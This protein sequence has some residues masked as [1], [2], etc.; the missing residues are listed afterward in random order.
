MSLHSFC[1][2]APAISFS[3]RIGRSATRLQ[4]SVIHESSL[5]FI[6]MEANTGSRK[7][8]PKL[9]NDVEEHQLLLKQADFISGS[10]VRHYYRMTS[11]PILRNESY[12]SRL[13]N[14]ASTLQHEKLEEFNLS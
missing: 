9:V 7:W 6:R 14:Q 2:L 4:T 5:K 12:Q 11:H 3:V 1:L 13:K 8:K 10:A